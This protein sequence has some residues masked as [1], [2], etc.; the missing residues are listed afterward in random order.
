MCE[1]TGNLV[2]ESLRLDDRDVIDDTLVGVEIVGESKYWLSMISHLLSV[3]SLDD[4]LGRSL[5][6]LGS[7]SSL[8]ANNSVRSP[9]SQLMKML[10][11][12]YI[13]LIISVLKMSQ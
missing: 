13:Y 3:V 9:H 11:I 7:N 1:L 2:S 8:Q 10:T 5:N 6:S 4:G 12:C